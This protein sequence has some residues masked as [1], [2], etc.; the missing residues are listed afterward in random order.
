MFYLSFENSICRDYVTE[1]FWEPLRR[2]IVPVV[3][4]GGNYSSIAPYHSNIDVLKEGFSEDTKGLAN[5]L[6]SLS[7]NASLYARYFWWKSY[8]SVVENTD[9]E[10]AA[11]PCEVCRKLHQDQVWEGEG[12]VDI[13]DW[14]VSQA[15]CSQLISY[16]REILRDLDDDEDDLD[17]YDDDIEK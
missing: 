1:K 17:D 12:G 8:Y 2:N 3:L 6:K 10:R 9:K 11:A 7:N 4:G 13:Y 5:L 16:D 14:W 15:S